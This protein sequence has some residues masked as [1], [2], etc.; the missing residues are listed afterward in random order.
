MP[1]AQLTRE[2][3]AG[4]RARRSRGSERRKRSGAIWPDSGENSAY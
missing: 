2:E 3:V 4:R 1:L